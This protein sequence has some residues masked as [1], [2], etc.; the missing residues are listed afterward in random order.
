MEMVHSIQNIT[1]PLHLK[2]V[3]DSA[4][5]LL[6]PLDLPVF[7][8]TLSAMLVEAEES[9]ASFAAEHKSRLDR[10]TPGDYTAMNIKPGEFKVQ[11]QYSR[12]EELQARHNQILK[13]KQKHLARL[14]RLWGS[15][16][17]EKLQGLLPPEPSEGLLWRLARFANTFGEKLHDS[18]LRE[19]L[20]SI[21]NTRRTSILTQKQAFLQPIDIIRFEE[22]FSTPPL[23]SARS[24]NLLS[25]M[26][27]PE[28]G[29]NAEN[30][31]QQS[32]TI[33]QRVEDGEIQHGK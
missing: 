15:A 20:Q 17:Q 33:Y 6:Q 16:W 2:V 24:S 1:D 27:G 9:L 3:Y 11:V 22:K 19:G 4:V 8:K 32:N 23:L 31:Q 28:A 14:E 10:L 7:Y 18:I 25:S 30:S 29:T 13:K 26:T 12:I 21:I 5:N